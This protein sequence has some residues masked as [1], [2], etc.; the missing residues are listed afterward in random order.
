MHSCVLM[1]RS[2]TLKEEHNPLSSPCP[3][4]CVLFK[5]R[6]RWTRCTPNYSKT[7]LVPKQV[8]G[9]PCTTY[10]AI[11]P[12]GMGF[13]KL[14]KLFRR[15]QRYKREVSC[16]AFSYRLLVCRNPLLT[17]LL[18]PFQIKG[19]EPFFLCLSCSRFREGNAQCGLF[20]FFF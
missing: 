1:S 12:L 16:F 18:L 3:R 11:N 9:L 15:E 2:V 13:S 6:G 5:M 20:F 8:F 7:V 17:P 19:S 10:C 14:Q 4:P